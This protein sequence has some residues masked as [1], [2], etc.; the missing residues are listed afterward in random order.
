MGSQT[1]RKP[2]DWIQFLEGVHPEAV[3]KLLTLKCSRC[4]NRRPLNVDRLG[5]Y[6]VEVITSRF[7]RYHGKCL[8]NGGRSRV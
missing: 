5:M 1:L 8:P 6:R 7:Q 2:A 4:G 3:D